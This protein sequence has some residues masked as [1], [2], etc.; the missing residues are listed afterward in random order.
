[1]NVICMRMT[2]AVIKE[3]NVTGKQT[4]RYINFSEAVI[5]SFSVQR[6]IQLLNAILLLE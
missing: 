4:R 2:R 3:G 1:M 5:I 6:I